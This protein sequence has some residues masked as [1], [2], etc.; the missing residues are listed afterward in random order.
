MNDFRK[1]EAAAMGFAQVGESAVGGLLAA[2]SY[3]YMVSLGWLVG[4]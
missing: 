2:V 4:L 3:C 1:Q